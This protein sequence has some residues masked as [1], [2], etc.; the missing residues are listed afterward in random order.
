M[1]AFDAQA[2]VSPC[3]ATFSTMVAGIL[4]DI[5]IAS[6]RNTPMVIFVGATLAGTGLGPLISGFV[7]QNLSWRW[8]WYIQTITCGILMAAVTFFF[9]ETRGSV[10][11]S[12]KAKAL[13]KWYEELE[14]A[15]Y[16]GFQIPQTNGDDKMTKRQRVRWKVKSDE[17]RATLTVMIKTSLL[18][19][20]HFL[21]TESVVF[22][23]SAW[24]A[25]S[26]GILYL[27]FDAVPLVFRTNH[28]FSLQET[29]AVFSAMMVG[30]F[31]STVLSIFQEK[32]ALRFSPDKVAATPEGRLY[33]A[34][35]ESFLMPIGLFMFGWTSQPSIHWIV[36]SIAITIA[37]MG[38][39]S[40]YLATFNYLADIYHK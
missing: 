11:L 21:F 10:L 30:A 22:W 19:P 3:A 8:I 28:N 6:E 27:T 5:Y 24:V 35:F 34:C 2:D 4:A 16:I 31:L 38:I 7:G 32:L 9:K 23:F 18:R 25:F 15:G 36:P 14:A 40:I 1:T 26:W 17:Q 13:N 12:R 20:F 37:T 29:G 39:F 33:F